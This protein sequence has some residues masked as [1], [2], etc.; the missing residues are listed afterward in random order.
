MFDINEIRKRAQ[1]ASEQASDSMKKAIEKSE[2]RINEIEIPGAEKSASASAAEVEEQI[3]ANT[4]RQ[5]SGHWRDC[6]W[7]AQRKIGFTL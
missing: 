5:D 6:P 1:Q 2:K 7:P 4:G 3:A